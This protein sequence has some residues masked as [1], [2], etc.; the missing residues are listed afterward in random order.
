MLT[1]KR[2]SSTISIMV[3]GFVM[4]ACSLLDATTDTTVQIT[5]GVSQAISDISSSTTPSDSAETAHQR[6]KKLHL[7]AQYNLEN[8]QQDVARGDG[9]YLSSLEALLD[10]PSERHDEFARF[11]QSRYTQFFGSKEMTHKQFIQ[12]AQ[13]GSEEMRVA[14]HSYQIEVVDQRG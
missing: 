5:N 9:E 1:L 3:I 12:M 6:V 7:F 13:F 8:L 10:V 14:L 4:S 2:L 11:V